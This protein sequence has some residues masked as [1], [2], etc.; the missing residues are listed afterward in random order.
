M[1]K[2]E[3]VYRGWAQG[4]GAQCSRGGN[5]GDFAAPDGGRYGRIAT[6]ELCDDTAAKRVAE[7]FSKS[8]LPPTV[9][10]TL[11]SLYCLRYLS[12]LL[13]SHFFSFFLSL[14]CRGLKPL[15]L[16]VAAARNDKESDVS[17]SGRCRSSAEV[18]GTMVVQLQYTLN[19]RGTRVQKRVERSRGESDAKRQAANGRKLSVN[20]CLERRCRKGVWQPIISPVL[21]E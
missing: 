14:L 1:G 2:F 4:G 12:C 7:I 6:F 18:V 8:L 17:Y 10:P 5:S 19:N 3:G 20:S 15:A 13:L 16:E 21:P 11:S 9:F